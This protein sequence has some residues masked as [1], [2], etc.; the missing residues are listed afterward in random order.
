M[1]GKR[2]ILFGSLRRGEANE[3][4][5]KPW[6]PRG[7]ALRRA[8][9]TLLRA[10]VVGGPAPKSKTHERVERRTGETAK[11]AISSCAR[12]RAGSL[13]WHRSH[14][15]GFS[16][17]ELSLILAVLLLVGAIAAI[18]LAATRR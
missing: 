2:R 16:L 9:K 11:G 10:L 13:I 1:S 4:F 14:M 8:G 18:A 3:S 17:A 12:R 6:P 5:S 15:F 7:R